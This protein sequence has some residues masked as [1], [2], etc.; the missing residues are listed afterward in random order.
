MQNHIKKK[1]YYWSPGFVHIATF[2]AV[3]NSAFSI[4]KYS[5]DKKGYLLN[6]F[7]EFNPYIDEINEKNLDLI[8]HFNINFIRFFPKYGL[9][10]SR[11]SFFLIFLLS[12]F[13][14]KNKLNNE[15]PEYLIIH[16]VSS[17]PL[18]LLILFNFNT[19]FVL[20]ISGYP[21]L[22]FFRKT[23][24]KMAF[25]KIHSVTCPTKLTI[26]NLKK[27]K[28][29]DEKK[30]YLL[31][32]PILE[33]RKNKKKTSLKDDYFLSIGRL[34]KQKNFIFL[35][36]CI[37]EIKKKGLEN[38]K[39]YIA[40][41]SGEEEQKIKKF[42]ISNNLEKNIYLLGHKKN[43]YDYISKA[44]AVIV[45]SIYEDPGFVIVESAFL[46]TLVITSDCING[47]REI[48]KKNF[49]GI[50]FKSNDKQ[51]F[52]KE[53]SYFQNLDVYNCKEMI[54]NN[55]L[56]VKDFTLFNHFKNFSKIII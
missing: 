33:I 8:N 6:F 2:K 50:Q 1:I 34:T 27:E 41:E 38:I 17:L 29:I 18:C 36:Q 16:Q 32:D 46:R 55:F 19:K 40:G 25:K 37:N 30:L 51:S 9:I 31:Y 45:S 5:A 35:C 10:R 47:P 22:N 20:R 11:I 24:W 13:T 28:L 43:I 48:I 39:L 44:K 52:I 56:K 12:F 26:E 53:F 4:N 21:N 54:R 23:L 14:L 42:I 3:I 49:N 15:K 7:G